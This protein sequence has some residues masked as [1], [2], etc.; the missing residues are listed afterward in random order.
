M[1]TGIR[2]ASG[3]EFPRQVKQATNSCFLCWSWEAGT[4]RAGIAEHGNPDRE[5]FP[6]GVVWPYIKGGLSNSIDLEG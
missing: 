1:L 5:V 2:V 4:G 6:G 3:L